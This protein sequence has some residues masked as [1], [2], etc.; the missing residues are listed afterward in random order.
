M[1]RNLV[2]GV[3]GANEDNVRFVGIFNLEDLACSF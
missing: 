1:L 2:L 3:G